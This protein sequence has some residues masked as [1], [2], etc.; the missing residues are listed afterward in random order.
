MVYNFVDMMSHA[1][2]ELPM[3]RE[4][5]DDIAGYRALTKTWFE[6]SSLFTLL[7]M[8]S[9]TDYKVVF[10]TD[11]GTTRVSNPVKITGEKQLTSN[12]RYKSGQDLQLNPKEVFFVNDPEKAHLP[13]AKINS[14]YVFAKNRDFFVYPNNYNQYVKYYKETFQH[15][16]IS[17]EEM[18]IPLITLN[19]KKL[20]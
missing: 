1:R 18:L 3:M 16:G 7:K 4:L 19:P 14:K 17:M 5:A 12:L 15:G 11:H 2:T 10:T 13:P 6:H 8:I 20:K 9:D